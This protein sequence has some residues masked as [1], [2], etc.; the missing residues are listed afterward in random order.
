MRKIVL[1]FNSAKIHVVG[2]TKKKIIDKINEF[3]VQKDRVNVV[4]D[5]DPIHITY[6]QISNVLHVLCGYRPVPT[7]RKTLMKRV[8]VL[9]DIAKNSYICIDNSVKYSITNNETGVTTVKYYSEITQGKKSPY[10]SH[11]QTK[12]FS[13]DFTNC[14]SG[15]LTWSYLYKRYGIYRKNEYNELIN[16]FEK[17]YGD[18]FKNI[19]KKYRFYDFLL[20]LR[21][22]KYDKTELFD[23]LKKLPCV[24]LIDVLKGK[25]GNTSALNVNKGNNLAA[26]CIN[27]NPVYEVT[28]FG[29]IIVM[30]DD[31][32][33][34]VLDHII[35]G[36]G[37][38]TFLD[39]GVVMI[40]S[41]DYIEDSDFNEYDI[42]NDGF[43]KIE[44]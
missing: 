4:R 22:D 28:I 35:N 36:T 21:D 14:T 20:E 38:A 43:T 13:S 8:S 11:V 34:E 26:L 10:N 7:Y 29:K 17:T 9:D 39:D 5:N 18:T 24:P 32:Y 30:I 40:K 41:I 19:K 33:E 1:E 44:L 27:T 37:C 31:K 12:T 6:K 15:Y 3:G 23:F 42:L 16:L 25:D 2:E